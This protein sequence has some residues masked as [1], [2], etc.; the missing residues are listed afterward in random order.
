MLIHFFKS[1]F[2]GISGGHCPDAEYEPYRKELTRAGLSEE[3][4]R[5]MDPDARVAALEKAHLD[6]CNYIYLACG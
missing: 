2:C 4:L 5:R 3:K 6:P 1:M